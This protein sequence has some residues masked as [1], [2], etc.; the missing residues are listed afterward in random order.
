MAISEPVSAMETNDDDDFEFHIDDGDMSEP[1]G[2]D[3]WVLVCGY[4]GCCMPGYHF[5][6]E[7]HNAEDMEAM[8]AEHEQPA[9]RT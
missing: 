1:F 9:E 4:E 5:R 7:C 3:E 2:N 8:H 6:S